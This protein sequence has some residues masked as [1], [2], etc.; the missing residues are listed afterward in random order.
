M[1]RAYLSPSSP[2]PPYD[3]PRYARSMYRLTKYTKNRPCVKLVFL[4]TKFLRCFENRKKPQNNNLCV[5]HPFVCYC[6]YPARGKV[7][8]LAYQ[9]KNNTN[10]NNTFHSLLINLKFLKNFVHTV[11]H[12]KKFARKMSSTLLY[13]MMYRRK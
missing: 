6:A 7:D 9:N 13:T 8:N 2:V 3:G 1:F 10:K 12:L 4:Y 5:I 11:C